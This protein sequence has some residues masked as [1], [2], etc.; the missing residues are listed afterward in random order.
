M[1]LDRVVPTIKPIEIKQGDGGNAKVITNDQ[2]FAA[3]EGTATRVD[4]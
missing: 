2:L 3:I 4:K 1:L